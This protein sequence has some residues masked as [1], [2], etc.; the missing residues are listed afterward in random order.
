MHPFS[1]V[2]RCTR[3]HSF[4]YVTMQKVGREGRPRSYLSRFSYLGHRTKSTP[5]AGCL[6]VVGEWIVLQGEMGKEESGA[7]SSTEKE[8]RDSW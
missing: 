5:G 4:R 1:T 6:D 2:C 3:A 7:R 8:R